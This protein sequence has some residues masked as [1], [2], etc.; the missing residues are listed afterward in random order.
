MS[1][2]RTI[3]VPLD[4][5]IAS[6]RALRPAHQLARATGATVE[7]LSVLPVTL[8]T[9]RVE[10]AERYLEK[11]VAD[12]GFERFDVS[13]LTD[14]PTADAIV[15]A[16]AQEDAIVCMGTHGHA[17]ITEV[18]LGSTADEV[19]RQS[20][21]PILFIGPHCDSEWSLPD[22]GNVVVAVDGSDASAE[23]VAPALEFAHQLGLR[24]Y[25]VQVVA[26]GADAL[27]EVGYL[28]ELAE[29]RGSADDAQW[30]VLHGDSPA[31]AIAD[32]VRVLPAAL[33]AAATHG[34]TGIARVTAGS[35]ATR[36]VRES[37]CPVLVRRPSSLH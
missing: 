13:V 31:D 3:V 10:E 6:E 19:V 12:E 7:L 2:L 27:S 29:S 37:P 28:H 1:P 35:V 20:D 9:S 17:G 21:Q 4:G 34:R 36:I 32:Y 15:G 14:Q 23:I 26:V 11:H 5:S 24:P 16:A 22:G 18:L 33:V 30:E 25:V 8:W